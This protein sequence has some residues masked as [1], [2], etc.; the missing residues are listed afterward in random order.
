MDDDDDDDDD[1]DDMRKTKNGKRT[2]NCLPE[3]FLLMLQMFP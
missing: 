2:G 1:G 3:H